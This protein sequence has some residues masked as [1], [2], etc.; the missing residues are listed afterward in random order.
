MHW[1]P[2]SKSDQRRPGRFHLDPDLEF[3]GSTRVGK[4]VTR[5][6]RGIIKF[7]GALSWSRPD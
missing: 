6:G 4:H 2:G 5:G 3:V 1:T 7:Q